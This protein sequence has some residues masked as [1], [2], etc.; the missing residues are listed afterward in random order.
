MFHH[1][2]QVLL[3]ISQSY[4]VFEQHAPNVKN[5]YLLSRKDAKKKIRRKVVALRLISVSPCRCVETV[6]LLRQTHA[7]FNTAEKGTQGYFR[8]FKISSLSGVTLL[9]K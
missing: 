4:H 8:Y 5:L 3:G 6:S 7:F 2:G 1:F 9:G